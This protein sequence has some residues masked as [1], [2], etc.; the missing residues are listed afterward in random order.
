MSQLTFQEDS[1][2]YRWGGVVV[3]SV[4]QA[5]T[6]LY[7]FTMVDPEVLER[8]RLIGT[9][10]HAAIDISLSADGLDTASIDPAWAGYYRAWQKFVADT[11]VGE[12]DIGNGEEPMYHK[13]YGYAGK[14]DRNIFI[15]GE[16]AVIDYKTAVDLHPAVGLQL[17]A[18]REMINS[19][20]SKE[21]RL[22]KSRYALQLRKNGTY[23]LAKFEDKSDWSAFLALLTVD[24]WRRKHGV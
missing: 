14:P 20:T 8:K 22:I 6:P 17:A 19:N 13:K 15:D 2:T 12:A 10:V 7:D 24:S 21:Q 18:Y 9:A 5:L 3:P 23:R 1:H 11:G 16:W 4:T